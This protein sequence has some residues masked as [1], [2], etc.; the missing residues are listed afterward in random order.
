MSWFEIPSALLPLRERAPSVTSGVLWQKANEVFLLL[1]EHAVKG[2]VNFKRHDASVMSLQCIADWWYLT[3]R[4]CYD[5]V[6]SFLCECGSH[7]HHHSLYDVF[8]LR[9][10]FYRRVFISTS[11]C[12]FLILCAL[13]RTIQ[14]RMTLNICYR[15]TFIDEPIPQNFN[16]ICLELCCDIT[17]RYPRPNL[18][19]KNTYTVVVLSWYGQSSLKCSQWKPQ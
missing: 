18:A 3:I 8:F 1:P 16:I 15:Y 9:T 5:A 11:W 4:F 12:V 7:T 19:W 17:Y 10:Y 2:T 14:C 6:L 13:G